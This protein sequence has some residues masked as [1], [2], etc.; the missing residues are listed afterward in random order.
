MEREYPFYGEHTLL[1]DD[2]FFKLTTDTVLLSY[3]ARVKKGER[4]IDL[5]AGVGCLG[6]LCMLRNPGVAVDGVE[7]TDVPAW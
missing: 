1:M 5:G 6:L 3:F 4:G 2:R 7:L